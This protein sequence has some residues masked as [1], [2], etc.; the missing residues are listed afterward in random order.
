MRTSK[1]CNLPENNCNVQ[2]TLQTRRLNYRPSSRHWVSSKSTSYSYHVLMQ[3]NARSMGSSFFGWLKRRD[4]QRCFLNK[5]VSA[6]LEAYSISRQAIYLRRCHLG[7]T[8]SQPLEGGAGEFF[9]FLAMRPPIVRQYYFSVRL[10][11]FKFGCI[12][13]LF[14]SQFTLPLQCVRYAVMLSACLFS[15]KEMFLKKT[16]RFH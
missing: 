12:F 7:A 1:R 5:E 13:L 2:C 11:D 8:S 15:I 9:R 4:A 6:D 3:K 16:I 10:R 14:F